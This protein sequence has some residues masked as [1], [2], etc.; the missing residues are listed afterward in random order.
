MKAKKFDRTGK[1]A[2]EVQ[3]PE[4]VFGLKINKSVIHTALR[5]EQRNRR[6]GTHQ[7]KGFS[8]VSGGGKKPWGQKHTGNARQGS[9]RAPQWRHGATVHG[10]KPRDYS[11]KMNRD[12]RKKAVAFVFGLKGE[13]GAV[14]VMED[15]QMTEFSTRTVFGALKTTGLIPGNTVAYV[16]DSD[17]IKLKKSF[18]N[19]P[20]VRFVHARR[21]TIPELYNS[22]H[23]VVSDSAL[24][25]L[26][27]AYGAK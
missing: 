9:T 15:M 26:S 22:S 25:Y 11:V 23:V 24:K 8:D 4:S 1:A 3:L 21:I 27:E 18:M 5:S 16:V 2:G 19:I 20:V 13:Q 12:L 17:D 10:P 6:Q 14:S 7:T